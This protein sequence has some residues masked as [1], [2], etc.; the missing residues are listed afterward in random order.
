VRHDRAAVRDALT[1]K[2]VTDEE[3]SWDVGNLPRLLEAIGLG[4]AFPGWREEIDAERRAAGER[5]AAEEAAR[6]APPP[7]LVQPILDR[8]GAAEPAPLA[9][10]PVAASPATLWRVPWACENEVEVGF[11]VRPSRAVK[12]RWPRGLEQLSAIE[13]GGEWRVGHPWCSVWLREGLF[14]KLQTVFSALPE[15]STIEVVCASVPDPTD[16]DPPVTAGD[17]R[18]RSV[19]ERGRWKVTHAFPAVTNRDLKAALKIFD[20]ISERGAFA[21]RTAAEAVAVAELGRKHRHFGD[22]KKDQPVVSGRTITVRARHWRPYLAMNLFRHRF[23]EGPWDVRSGLAAEQEATDDFD[24]M[25]GALGDKLAKELAAPRGEETVFEGKRSLFRRADI[26]EV[27]APLN[28]A[29]LFRRLYPARDPGPSVDLPQAVAR[30]DEAMTSQGMTSLGD[31][32]CE[33]FG[34]V[35]IRGYAREAGDVYGLTYAGTLG[36]FVYEFNTHFTDGSALTT[37]IHRGE[38]RKELKFHHAQ[39]PNASVEELLEH[40]LAAVDKR[41]TE[42]VKPAPHPMALATLAERIDDFLVRTA[43]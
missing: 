34:E 32:V 41:T 7:D 18:F 10:G 30:V 42:K 35:V 13:I 19:I 29:D 8:L 15:G 12:P 20:W 2:S 23:A 26:L 37:S 4:E 31:M 9:G 27:R 39:F 25:L 17:M 16:A 28:L 40:H 6:N 24:R 43:A 14:Q 1:G 5:R 11:I 21:T 3:R 38:N 22:A 36:Q 33:A